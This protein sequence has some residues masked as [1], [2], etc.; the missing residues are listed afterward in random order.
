MSKSA[1]EPMVDERERYLPQKR[2]MMGSSTTEPRTMGRWVCQRLAMFVLIGLMTA[3]AGLLLVGSRVNFVTLNEVGHIPA[4]VSHW[5]T[6]N[7][8]L[9]RVNPPLGGCW[10]RY[11]FFSQVRSSTIAV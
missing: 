11:L 2:N 7:F 5:Q 1:I 8:A 4:G 10:Q 3:H 9:Y 6:R